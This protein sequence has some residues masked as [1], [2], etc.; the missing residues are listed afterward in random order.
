MNASKRNPT[1]DEGLTAKM[2]GDYAGAISIFNRVLEEHPTSAAAYHQL[3]RCYM[4]L[5]DLESAIERL[6]TAIS[7]GPDR[8][9]AR[10][11]AG[12]LYLSVGDVQRARAQ[13]LRALKLNSSN[14]KAMAGL[15]M[16]YYQDQDYGKAISQFQNACGLNPSNFVC[17][18]YLARIHKALKNEAGVA[19]EAIKSAAICQGLIR[20]RPDQPEGYFFL[21]ETFMLQDDYRSALQNYLIAKDFSAEGVMVFF[22][23]GLS[24][25]VIDNYLGIARCYHLLGE[26][27]YARYFGEL[28]L[29]LDPAN[30]EATQFV[31]GDT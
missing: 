30:E 27:R 6:E 15:G 20:T 31:S 16:A 18:F 23:F 3:G 28:T 8:I 12:M 13:F 26:S 7:L 9:A 22:A 29:R 1:F 5:G 11:D 14:V 17:H 4:K 25:T 10:L 19:E 24:Y 2:R 21:A